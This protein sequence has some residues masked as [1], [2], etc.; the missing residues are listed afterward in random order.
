MLGNDK[1]MSSET[2]TYVAFCNRG[3]FDGYYFRRFYLP[4]TLEEVPAHAKDFHACH[5]IENNCQF[6]SWYFL[7]VLNYTACINGCITWEN[8]CD[9][10][11]VGRDGHV[12]PQLVE[13]EA[14]DHE[15]KL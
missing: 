3:N 12:Y 15:I 6:A 1:E 7:N 8:F 13:L 14:F 11:N 5:H 4:A 10:K 9:I 2:R